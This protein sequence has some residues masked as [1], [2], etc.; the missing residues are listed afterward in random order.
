MVVAAG[1]ENQLNI[2]SIVGLGEVTV[3]FQE[4]MNANHRMF[5][6]GAM[7][8]NGNGPFANLINPAGKHFGV[9]LLDRL[10]QLTRMGCFHTNYAPVVDDCLTQ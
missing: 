5:G 4:A 2:G 8:T 6:V 10:N 9:G 3:I 1:Q 7:I